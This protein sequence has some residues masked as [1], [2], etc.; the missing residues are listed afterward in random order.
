MV[1]VEETYLTRMVIG[2]R[3]QECINAVFWNKYRC[4]SSVSIGQRF[5]GFLAISII[6]MNA[7]YVPLIDFSG[8]RVGFLSLV[9]CHKIGCNKSNNSRTPMITILSGLLSMLQA[10]KL[11]FPAFLFF[12]GYA[13][14]CSV[15]HGLLGRDATLMGFGLNNQ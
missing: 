6:S 4:C 10:G 1:L 11:L 12:F 14:I 9:I 15:L 7:R 8:W 5:S 2:R 13:V 3:L